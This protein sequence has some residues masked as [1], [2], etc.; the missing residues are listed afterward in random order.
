M[1]KA[2]RKVRRKKS[3][4]GR[5]VLGI[6]TMINLGL[7]LALTLQRRRNV[8]RAVKEDGRVKLLLESSVEMKSGGE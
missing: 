2:G 5:L 1:G 8:L 6:V 3:V 7:S 4:A